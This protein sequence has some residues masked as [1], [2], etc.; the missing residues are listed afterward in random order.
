MTGAAL[1]S[2]AES[3]IPGALTSPTAV[4]AGVIA[5]LL[6][7]TGMWLRSIVTGRWIHVSTVERTVSLYS[8]QTREA[9]AGQDAALAVAQEVTTQMRDLNEGMRTILEVVRAIQAARPR[10]AR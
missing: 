4:L 10:S 6:G 3:A 8:A 1:W 9:K 7:A 5:V 2:A